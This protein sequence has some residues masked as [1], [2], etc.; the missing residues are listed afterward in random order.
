MFDSTEELH[1]AYKLL[2]EKFNLWKKE[3]P[4]N[5]EYYNV[6][7]KKIINIPIDELDKP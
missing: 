5:Y 1:H 6:L 7:E 3:H 4:K 2:L